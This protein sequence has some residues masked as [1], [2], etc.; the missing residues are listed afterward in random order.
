MIIKSYLSITKPGIVLGNA[1]TAAGGFI[2]ASSGAIDPWLLLATLLG[3][4]LVM[5]AACIFN[6]YFDRLSD[7]KMV[8]TQNRPL[9]KGAI[10]NRNALLFGAFLGLS[11]T[12]LLLLYTHWLTLSLAL[13]GFA[14][15]VFLY[16]FLKYR[17]VHA[18]L[19]GSLAGS[20]P[21]VAGYAAGSHALDMAALILFL[22][23]VFWQMPHFFAIALYRLDDYEAASIPVLPVKRGSFLTKV[24]M[25]LYIVAFTASALLLSLL[26]YVGTRY[27]IAIVLLSGIWLVLSLRGFKSRDDKAWARQMFR[28]SL[29]TITTLSVMISIDATSIA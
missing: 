10:S 27:L 24:Q 28:Y 22:V 15:Y 1:I 17:S 20:V 19:V 26:G 6:N 8:R 5:A 4:S 23:M 2:L 21:L 29:I 7:R 9:A 13:L 11:G 18:T 3:L 12:L 16:T 25:A 14:I